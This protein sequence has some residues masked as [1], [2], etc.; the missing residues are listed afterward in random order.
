M[1]IDLMTQLKT[2]RHLGKEMGTWVLNQNKEKK[3]HMHLFKTFKKLHY[4]N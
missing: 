4:S 3:T 2:I 1:S